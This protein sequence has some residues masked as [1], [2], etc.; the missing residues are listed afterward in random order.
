MAAG[1]T[2]KLTKAQQKL[3]EQLQESV[4]QRTGVVAAD[5]AKWLEDNYGEYA[6]S[7]VASRAIPS[8]YSGFKPVH[9]RILDARVAVRVVGEHQT[10]DRRGFLMLRGRREAAREGRP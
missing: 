10:R 1:K 3:I 8:V 6:I 4:G 5:S 2:S 7:T 9:A